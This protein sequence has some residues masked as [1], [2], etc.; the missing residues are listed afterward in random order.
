MKQR[1]GGILYRMGLFLMELSQTLIGRGIS[2][3]SK[4]DEDDTVLDLRM[5][6]YRAYDE[7]RLKFVPGARCFLPNCQ[8]PARYFVLLPN[9]HIAGYCEQHAIVARKSGLDVMPE[10]ITA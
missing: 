6:F 9:F 10:P 3:A 7:G 1:L 2:N 4:G 8:N 5:A